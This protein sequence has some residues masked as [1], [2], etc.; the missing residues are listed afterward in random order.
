MQSPQASQQTSRGFFKS[1]STNKVYV[2]NFDLSSM[3]AVSYLGVQMYG[4]FFFVKS[5]K[6]PAITKKCAMKQR[7]Y[8][9]IPRK[10]CNSCTLQGLGHSS[11]IVS[12]S[13][14]I[15]IPSLDIMC[16]KYLI[17]LIKNLL[18][19]P[20]TQSLLAGNSSKTMD[21]KYFLSSKV[22]EWIIMSSKKTPM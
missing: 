10:I 22:W 7:Q 8:E 18:F 19:F 14:S 21:C 15:W 12:F 2:I 17:S 20:F 9:H 6:G 11:I 16:P 4:T 13:W 1:G 5:C 3:K